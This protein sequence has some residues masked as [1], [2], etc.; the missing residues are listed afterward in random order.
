MR[1]V[2]RIMACII[3]CMYFIT[4]YPG[5]GGTQD[6]RLEPSVSEKELSQK[7]TGCIDRA[8]YEKRLVGAVVLVSYDGLLIYSNAAG[9]RDKEAKLAMRE[10]TV[11]RLASVSKVYTAM[12]VAA[13]ADQNILHLDDYV[14]KWL[15]DFTPSLPNGETPDITIRQ[16]LSHTA[17]LNYSFQEEAD[18]EYH[19][20]GI[21][22]GLDNTGI[23]LNENVRRIAATPLLYAPGTSWRYSVAMDVVGAVVEKVTGQSLPQSVQKL[24]TTPLGI[25]DSTFSIAKNDNLAVPYYNS[26]SL[27][28]LRMQEPENVNL[29][30]G[31]VVHFSPGRIFDATAF[32]AGGA[33]M[34]GTAPDLMRLLE[35]IRKGG[36][37]IAS[38]EIIKE[39]SQRQTASDIGR[40]GW[41]FALGWSVLLDPAEAKSPQSSGT[42][43][44]GGAYGHSWFIDPANK[45]SVVVMTNT[46]P[47]GMD[48]QLL[49]DVRDAV[50]EYVLQSKQR[51]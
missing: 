45:L 43:S 48:G 1:L 35:T 28:P 23:S 27:G 6:M 33:G 9:Y 24:V 18:G 13:L 26:V 47:E 25:T 40:P 46:T 39:M 16:L 3:S 31:M 37:P 29:G 5:Q 14:S 41:S 10:D 12:A 50:Y 4:S 11:F 38:S 8:I 36:S 42:L 2:K 7:L 20:A 32:P 19:K 17:G 44:W 49:T 22:D 15:P 34:A 51:E 21:S 30:E